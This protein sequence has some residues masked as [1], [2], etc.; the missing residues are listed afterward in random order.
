MGFDD[1]SCKECTVCPRDRPGQY[2]SVYKS[3]NGTDREDVVVCALNPAEISFVGDACPAGYF[4]QG[5]LEA[6]DT[7]MRRLEGQSLNAS[8]AGFLSPTGPVRGPL[9]VEY[10]AITHYLGIY[11][12]VLQPTTGVMMIS[13]LVLCISFF[14]YCT[15]ERM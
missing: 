5:R 4:V 14:Q 9:N 10:D 15:L 8:F 2:N 6:I 7:E 1:T 13:R 12:P 3:C 11:N